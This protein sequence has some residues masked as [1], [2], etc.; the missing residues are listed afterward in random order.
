MNAPRLPIHKGTHRQNYVL[1]LLTAVYALNIA[2][3]FVMS[4]LIE[5]IKADL[6]LSDSAVAFLTG[7]ALAVFYVFAGLPIAT[8]AD[9]VNRR[10]LIAAALAAWSLMTAACSVTRS[11][12]QLFLCRVGVGVGEAGG[13][14]PSH[15][16]ICDY[17]PW[18]RRAFALSMYSVGASVGSMIGSS[19]GYISDAWGW[20][21]ALLT[22]G[23]PGVLCALLLVTTV[24]EPQRGEFDAVHATRLTGLNATWR[25]ALR[26]PALLHCW[27]GG[28][29]Y[30]FWAWGLMWWTT[31]FLVRSYDIPLG[32]AGGLL[33]L[34]HGI[35]GTAVLLG[36][37]T[38][39]SKTSA[40][41]PR[42][43][44]WFASIVIIVATVPSILAYSTTSLVVS[45]IMMWIFI[46]ISYAIFGPTFA[47]AQNLVP[48]SM[49]SQS[50]ALLLFFSNIANL[51]FAPQL[52]GLVSD[53][54]SDRYGR[55]SLRYALIPLSFT[56]FWAAYHY[57]E[58]GRG[59]RAGL[60][61]AG[62]AEP[63]S[64]FSDGHADS[65]VSTQK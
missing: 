63:D 62:T 29:I 1:A 28:T 47:L 65:N 39:M 44:P 22:L 59:L 56:G 24:V 57:W 52:I 13:T 60:A 35:G 2:D 40:R 12:G 32:K 14:P 42:F 11:F 10:N 64:H 18:R 3:R 15:S 5:P 19:A 4:T 48:A 58:A 53:G 7:I 17:F 21:I 30:T 8:L 55:N 54:L 51:I 61:R 9:R 43:V 31:S 27:A 37:A 26:Q 16:M 25:F 49:R 46:P 20:R 45:I 23:V 33:A 38:L 41:D 50:S 34:M 6:H 36:T